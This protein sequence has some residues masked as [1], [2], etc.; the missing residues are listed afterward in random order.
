MDERINEA[1]GLAISRLGQEL[2]HLNDHR[3]E[4]NYSTIY[5]T[6]FQ[7]KLKRSVVISSFKV[8]DTEELRVAKCPGEES[9]CLYVG[10]IGDNDWARE[11]VKIA[12]IKEEAMH[13]KAKTAAPLNVLTITYEDGPHDAEG[14]SIHPNGDLY[15]LT[16][17]G[18]SSGLYRVS[19][20]QLK[21]K[22]AKAVLVGQIKY[23]RI[24][25]KPYR[26]EEGKMVIDEEWATSM[27]IAPDGKSFAVMT[28]NDILIYPIDLAS[29]EKSPLRTLTTEGKRMMAPR[30]GQQEALA[31]LGSNRIFYN[32]EE[33]TLMHQMVCKGEKQTSY[34]VAPKEPE[35]DDGEEEE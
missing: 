14:M 27:D 9:S 8:D 28:Y 29:L 7:G 10:D 23:K 18:G 2:Y 32:S 30:L 11:S 33:E 20:E 22:R 35:E 13:A 31:Y 3:D 16:K 24:N 19:K 15:I 21:A 6:D 1:S 4:I 25:E 26:N 17:M 5:V 12:I 34:D